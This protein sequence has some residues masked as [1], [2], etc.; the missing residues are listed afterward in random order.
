MYT[1][2]WIIKNRRNFLEFS[3]VLK[4]SKNPRIYQTEFIHALVDEFW[5]SD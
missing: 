5:E 3:R 1:V 4:E 2:D